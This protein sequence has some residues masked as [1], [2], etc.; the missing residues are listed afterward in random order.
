MASQITEKRKLEK[1]P[2]EKYGE[3]DEKPCY[4][5]VLEAPCLFGADEIEPCEQTCHNQSQP[6][7]GYG[8][9]IS[10]IVSETDHIKGRGE[11]KAQPQTPPHNRTHHGTEG[12]HSEQVAAPGQRHAG[13]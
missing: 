4:D 2:H 3:H 10:Y 7:V 13:G 8:Q 11:Y 9:D 5:H 1:G 12:P 6:H